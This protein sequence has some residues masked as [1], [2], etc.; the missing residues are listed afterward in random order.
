MALYSGAMAKAK[1]IGTVSNV[2]QAV[3]MGC[4]QFSDAD[5][6]APIKAAQDMSL[7]HGN[8]WKGG[9]RAAV[10]RSAVKAPTSQQQLIMSGY[11]NE[12]S[13]ELVPHY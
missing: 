8:M 3:T 6:N 11:A 12:A 5:K 9:S 2:L 1:A 7:K 4:Q 13:H 10:D